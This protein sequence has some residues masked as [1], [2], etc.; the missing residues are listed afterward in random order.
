MHVRFRCGQARGQ[1]QARCE[2]WGDLRLRW[3]CTFAALLLGYH[4]YLRL[5]LRDDPGYTVHEV[6]RNTRVRW[7]ETV[8]SSDECDVLAVQTLSNSVMAA[9][10]MAST[11]ILLMIGSLTLS[12]TAH[13]AGIW[14]NLNIGNA[15]GDLLTIKLILLLADFFVAFFCFSMAVRFFNHVGYMVNV[16]RAA[17]SKTL[18]PAHVAA[19]LNRAGDY[20]AY[21]MCTFFFCV[22]LVFWLFGPHFML[23]A[24]VVLLAGLYYLD[25]APYSRS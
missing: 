16:P 23:V 25:R 14:H 19:Y 18:T 3:F 4:G 9:S 7:V 1:Q 13:S 6:T 15:H 22:P 24:M 8:M 12:G 20:Y 17:L 10:F 5:R 11:A 21:D 2:V